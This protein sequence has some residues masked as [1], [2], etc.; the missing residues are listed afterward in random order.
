[1]I[2]IRAGHLD[3]AIVE[4]KAAREMPDLSPSQNRSLAIHLAWAYHAK[5]E[6]AEARRAFQ[7]AEASGFVLDAANPLERR[8]LTRL[9]Q[10]LGLAAKG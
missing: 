1:M 7:Q 4:L 8:F 10:D 5:G 3:E 9:R 6:A 2:L